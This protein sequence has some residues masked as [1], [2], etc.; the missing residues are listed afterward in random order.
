MKKTAFKAL[1]LLLIFILT[2]SA[3]SGCSKGKTSQKQAYKIYYSTIKKIV[4]ELMNK[5]QECDVDIITRDEVTFLGSHF[6]R[7]MSA[8][9][10]SQKVKGKLQYC[11]L[12]KSP[13]A[14][15]TT[16]Y[17]IKDNKFYTV[18]T[19]LN[20]NSKSTL[21]EQ[22][23]SYI[24]SVLFT[25]LNTPLFKEDAIKSFTAEKKGKNTEL[26]LIVDGAKTEEKFAQRVMKEIL[27]GADD[28]LEDVKI[29]LTVGK[30]GTPKKM[31]TELSMTKLH[32]NG[33]LYA[34]KTLNMDFVF[35]KL[36][37]VDFDL[38]KE[39]SKYASNPTIM[40]VDK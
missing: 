13:E 11:L 16:L 26:T 38:E 15:I 22:N 4:P 33:D 25:Y 27:A 36:K 17:C 19:Q 12:N 20:G 14:N 35:N 23:S 37:D 7:N 31:S 40:D 34:K 21:K 2:F 32:N 28:K 29:I 5:P 10:K 39:V 6:V 24:D 1:S 30:D 18:S 3:L 8:N 9:I